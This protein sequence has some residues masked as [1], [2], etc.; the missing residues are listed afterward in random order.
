MAVAH[1]NWIIGSRGDFHLQETTKA[2]PSPEDGVFRHLLIFFTR[3]PVIWLK[4]PAFF[5]LWNLG[6]TSN[7]L[8]RA[9]KTRDYSL[10]H[11]RMSPSCSHDGIA[12]GEKVKA[13]ELALLGP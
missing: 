7:P 4:A 12:D 1:N 10:K 2:I 13:T 11:A 8:H 6:V 9:K 5:H 3:G